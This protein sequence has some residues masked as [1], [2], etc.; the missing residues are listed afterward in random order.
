MADPKRAEGERR[1]PIPLCS[2]D[3]IENCRVNRMRLLSVIVIIGGFVGVLAWVRQHGNL[4][5][6]QEGESYTVRKS[7]EM[8]IQEHN[9][10]QAYT[11]TARHD[12]LGSQRNDGA[13][14]EFGGNTIEGAQQRYYSHVNYDD[15]REQR[16]SSQDNT[17]YTGD[18]K[19]LDGNHYEFDMDINRLDYSRFEKAK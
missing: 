9:G 7:T 14:I 1:A 3:S 19:T 4:W 11:G 16:G 10:Q 18:L 12:F 6:N 15:G 13:T 2:T 8:S 5:S 17:T